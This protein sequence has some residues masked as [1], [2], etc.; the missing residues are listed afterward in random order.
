MVRKSIIASFVVIVLTCGNLLAQ[1]IVVSVNDQPLNLVLAQLIKENNASIS[2]NDSG[3]SHYRVTANSTFDSL[4]EAISFL[5]NDLPLTY[6]MRG[7]VL[8]IFPKKSEKEQKKWTLSGRVIERGSAEPLPYSNLMVNNRGIISDLMGNFSVSS[9]TD[10]L[11]NIK[12]SH[13]GYY[14]LDTLV[15]GSS[16]MNFELVPSSFGLSEVVI[17]NSRVERSGQFGQKAGLIKLNH[18]IAGFLPGYGDNS[19]FNLLRLQPGILASGEQTSELIIWGSYEGHSKVVFDGFTIYGLKNFNDNISSFNPLM[20]KDIEIYKGGWDVTMGARVGGIVNISGKLGNINKTSFEFVANNM[21][22]NALIEIP[23]AKKGSLILA[24]RHTYYD[25]YDPSDLSVL[26]KR[27]ND[28]DTTNDADVVIKPDYKFRDINVKYATRL[29]KNEDL[30]YVSFYGGVDNFSYHIDEIFRTSQLLKNTSEENSQSGGSVFYGKKWSAVARSH[31]SFSYSS[32]RSKYFND[33]KLVFPQISKVNQIEDKRTDNRLTEASLKVDNSFS[34]GSRQTLETGA[35]IISNRVALVEDTFGVNYLNMQNKS[36]RLNMYAQ[37]VIALGNRLSMKVGMRLIYASLLKE[38]FFDPRLSMSY[39]VDEKWKINLAWGKYHQF[40]TR[41]SVL[42]EQGNY[43]YLWT[44]CDKVEIPVL[45]ADHYVAGT[46][47]NSSGFTF[48][49]EAYLK[50]TDGLTRFIRSEAHDIQDI[51]YGKSR[52]YGVDVM[53]KQDVR[54]HSF[55]VSYSLSKTEELF[56]Y[57]LNGKYRRA[58]QDQRH[59]LKLAGSL[60]FDPFFFSADYVVG[61]GFPDFVYSQQTGSESTTYLKTY[62]RLDVSV[63]YQ[64]LNRRLKGETGISILNVL[65]HENFKLENFERIPAGQTSTINIYA[66]AI[67][68]TPTLFLKIYL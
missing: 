41:S 22:L 60:N 33:F 64:F 17:E 42:D 65:N 56:T 37:D 7:A 66:E 16:Q 5:I 10:C 4:E 45:S 44:V 12:I 15:A 9:E 40:I 14:I 57:F 35:E 38:V 39:V 47:F 8:V 25:L 43:K 6:E 50:N 2:F 30:F 24:F 31:F 23:I 55:W 59:E 53:L 58:P 28:A 36:P 34:L 62:S 61:S 63:V 51:F 20:A 48:S 3:L 32:L 13:L 49:M 21:T 18:R 46:S 26:V 54:S 67:P 52:S 29:G 68:F 11:F 19:V 1:K 27:N